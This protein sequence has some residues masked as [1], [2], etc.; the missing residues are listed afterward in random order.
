[1]FLRTAGCPLR[2]TWCD[3]EY[4][5]HGG[6]DLPVETVVERAQEF[7]VPL[8]E[9]TGGEPLAQT[10]SLGLMTALADRGLTVLLETSGAFDIQPVDPRVHVI[11]DVKCP[12]SAMTDRMRWENLARLKPTD[13]LKF[14][15]GSRE[16]YEF[17]RRVIA[18]HELA[19]RAELLVSTV[20][21]A[22]DRRKVVEWILEDRLPV[23][24]QL[25]LHKH[26]W[27]PDARGV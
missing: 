24:F 23:R 1:V 18:E 26:I 8:V 15:V 14:V 6:E 7:R 11:M 16:D 5:F 10:S 4:A 25:Q 3:T 9:V 2:C 13:E 21:G 12:S 20:F 19:G 27:P 22:V 17:T